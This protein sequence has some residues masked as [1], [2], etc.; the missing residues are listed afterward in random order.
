M[1]AGF[2]QGQIW[3]RNRIAYRSMEAAGEVYNLRITLGRRAR[4][5]GVSR[6]RT[7]AVTVTAGAQPDTRLTGRPLFLARGVWIVVV[8]LAVG[9][10]L[11]SIPLQ[12]AY[13]QI[14]CSGA[15]CSG[16]QVSPAGLEQ[17]RQAGLSLGFY[18]GYFTTLNSIVALIFAVVAAVIFWRKS[19][20]RMGIFASLTLVVTGITFNNGLTP[21]GQ[22]YPALY[23]LSQLVGFLGWNCF[24][25][26]FYVFP[27]GRFVPRWFRWLALFVV[28]IQAVGAFRP[29]LLGNNWYWVIELASA[30]FAQIYRYWRVSNAVQR[31]QTKWVVFGSALCIGGIFGMTL[32]D[33]IL[34]PGGNPPAGISDLMITTAASL[35]ILLIPLSI[36]MA[37]LRSRLWDIDLLIRR[38]LVYAALTGL[39][40]LAYFVSVLVLEGLVRVL[41]GQSQSQV[42]TVVSTLA[43]AALFV[44]LR[45]G[46]QGFI[47]RRFYRRK[48]DAALTLAAFS[49]SVRDEVE[50]GRLTVHLTDV[51]EETLQPESVSLWIR[52]QTGA[53]VNLGQGGAGLHPDR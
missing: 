52:G 42:V 39:L 41:T 19:D 14:V 13:F 46:V 33:I 38:T 44:P 17:L 9:L 36:G 24:V 20:D 5:P 6:R 45:R 12:F 4:E 30:I 43:I 49:N 40:A 8:T 32:L 53:A 28:L 51:V 26:L 3:Q 22:Q 34:W 47:D 29:D 23:I 25:L 2:A 16:D 15:A 18:A 1:K 7:V 50:L 48:Y 21:I 10:Y 35:F 37:I 27:D 11:F 31:Q